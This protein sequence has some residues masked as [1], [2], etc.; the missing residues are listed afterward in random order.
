MMLPVARALL[1]D[2]SPV[3][4][5]AIAGDGSSVGGD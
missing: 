5:E 3:R 2:G 1:T 4:F